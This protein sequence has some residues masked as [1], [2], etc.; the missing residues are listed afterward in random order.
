MGLFRSPPGGRARAWFSADTAD[1]GAVP[2]FPVPVPASPAPTLPDAALPDAVDPIARSAY[3]TYTAH[4]TYVTYLTYTAYVGLFHRLET[5]LGPR[6]SAEGAPVS[7]TTPPI[8]ATTAPAARTAQ[9]APAPLEHRTSGL[10]LLRAEVTAEADLPL[11]PTGTRSPERVR[12]PRPVRIYRV[13]SD[14]PIATAAHRRT[15]AQEK[16]VHEPAE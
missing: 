9:V 1:R 16:V 6:G 8:P 15:H 5:P 14:S 11:A 12:R 13:M 10:P 2:T 4:D 7:D 3:D